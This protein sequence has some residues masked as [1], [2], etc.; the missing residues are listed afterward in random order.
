[1]TTQPA[2][3][4][5]WPWYVLGIAV[6]V[7]VAVVGLVFFTT[8][9]GSPEATPR[10]T[11][12]STSSTTAPPAVE[13][14]DGCL[15]G[16]ARSPQTVL[17]AQKEAPQTPEGAVSFVATFARWIAQ[18]PAVPADELAQIDGKASTMPNL[19]DSAASFANAEVAQF[20]TTTINGYYRIESVN[21]D[22]S[23]VAVTVML[24]LVINDAI[25]PTLRFTPSVAVEWTDAGWVVVE[26]LD[27]SG[28]DSL[29]TTGTALPGGC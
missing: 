9:G 4:R 10:P 14:V 7:I 6:F 8:R 12:P 19:A 17:D 23:R 15:A 25:D 1:M 3:R 18:K 24:P 29:P 20:H 5:R 22:S 28:T 27:T 16:D 13:G 21:E 11:A 2:A 26:D